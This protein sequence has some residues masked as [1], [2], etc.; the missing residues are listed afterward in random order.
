MDFEDWYQLYPRK[1]ARGAAMK[2]WAK[3]TLPERQQ[4]FDALPQHIHRWRLT[5]TIWE[6]IPHPATWLNQQRFADELPNNGVGPT[7]KDG[8]GHS[9]PSPVR[10]TPPSID[11]AAQ[12]PLPERH[13]PAPSLAIVTAAGSTRIHAPRSLADVLGPLKLAL[14][15]RH[16]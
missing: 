6:F 8:S 16:G 5:A 1:V 2:A 4:A 14:K 7:R 15:A 3:L 10:G 13:E 11:P 12:D 9:V